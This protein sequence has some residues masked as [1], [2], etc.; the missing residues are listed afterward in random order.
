M[1]LMPSRRRVVAADLETIVLGTLRV[2]DA[3]IVVLAAIVSY[4]PPHEN[5][6]IPVLYILAIFAAVVLTVNYMQMARL[7]VFA[8]IE[9]LASQIGR[10]AASWTAVILSLIAIAY[11]TQTSV[12]FS[13]AFVLGWFALS[14]GGLILV[15]L[16]LLLQIDR[17]RRA[18]RLSLNVAVIGAGEVGRHLIRQLDRSRGQYRIVG[19]FDDRGDQAPDWVEGHRV[20]GTIDDLVQLTR[21]FIIDE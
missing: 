14:F 6:Q 5:F 8:Q 16:V 15:R 13:R 21:T 20:L 9:R 4:Y 1:S 3:L 19:V 11:F 10:L 17:W 12:A 2:A 18:G 7:Y